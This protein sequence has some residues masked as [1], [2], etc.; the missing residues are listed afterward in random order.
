MYICEIII[1]SSLTVAESGIMA[2][3]MFK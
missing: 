1:S 3:T 2:F